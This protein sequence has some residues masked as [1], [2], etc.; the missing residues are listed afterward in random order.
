[1]YE[2]LLRLLLS[3]CNTSLISSIDHHHGIVIIADLFFLTLNLFMLVM[4]LFLYFFKIVL[5]VSHH[6]LFL[7]FLFCQDLCEALVKPWMIESICRI[8]SYLWIDAKHPLYKILG[9]I[10]KAIPDR[11]FSHILTL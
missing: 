10:T 5:F 11:S 7:F 9:S 3:S 1:M 2:H 6:N 8:Q 4:F